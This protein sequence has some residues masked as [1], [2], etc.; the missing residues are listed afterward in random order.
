MLNQIN[1]KVF[2]ET[3][4]IIYYG[5]GSRGGSLFQ[6]T[7]NVHLFTSDAFFQHSHQ[8]SFDVNNTNLPTYRSIAMRNCLFVNVSKWFVLP[9]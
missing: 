8:L 1:K 4:R 5:S 9:K 7:S 3:F 6:C 2:H